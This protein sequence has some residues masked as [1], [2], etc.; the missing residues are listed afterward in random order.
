M[1]AVFQLVRLPAGFSAISNVLAA[2]ILVTQADIQWEN[3]LLSVLASLCL[4][5]GGM[6]LNDCFDFHEDSRS[7][8]K[9]P[10]PGGEL[11]LGRA[12]AISIGFMLIG[13]SI[14]ALIGFAAFIVAVTLATA[15]VLYDSKILTPVLSA[16]AMGACR[17]LNWLLAMSVVGF[18]EIVFE[19]PLALFFYVTGLT[20]LSKAETHVESKKPLYQSI[21]FFFL[22]VMMLFYQVITLDQSL[23]LSFLTITLLVGFLTKILLP[24]SRD[25]S[26]YA[27]QA[28]TGQ[29][30]M[31]VII[32]DATVLAI[33]G[34]PMLAACI[35]LLLVPGKSLG[36]WLY[37]S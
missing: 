3:L 27:V 18:S 23:L 15:I 2:H 14:S 6:G 1:K 22:C 12:W 33:F 24:V 32:V 7:R 29:L 9:R 26:P 36:R 35:L 13:V 11:S 16:I 37:V 5:F 17:Y 31:G 21:V 30:V 34:F 25:F 10:L 20:L 28:A 19:L 4:Y 8:N